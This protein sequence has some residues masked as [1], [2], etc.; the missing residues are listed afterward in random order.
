[1]ETNKNKFQDG[2]IYRVCDVGY[3]KFYYGSTVQALAMRMGGHRSDYKRYK[4]GKANK[5]TVYDLFDEFGHENCKIE[6]VEPYPCDC[7]DVLLKREGYYIEHNECL[8]KIV[9]G[10]TTQEQKRLYRANNRDKLI[11]INREYYRQNKEECVRKRKEHYERN[12]EEVLAKAKVKT[13]CAVCGSCFRK[14]DISEHKRTLKHQKALKQ[15]TE[16]ETEP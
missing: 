4:A 2:K 7:R 9:V 14:S 8:N 13:T 6:L 12:K 10:R 16:P 3:T 15:Q 1:M 5:S 11:Q